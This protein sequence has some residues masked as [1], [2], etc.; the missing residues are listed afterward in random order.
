VEHL[1]HWDR[2][3]IVTDI[4]WI[5]RTAKLFAF[6]WPGDVRIYP[7]SEAEQARAWVVGPGAPTS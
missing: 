4:D 5:G 7:R 6:M 1:T 2:V 3:A